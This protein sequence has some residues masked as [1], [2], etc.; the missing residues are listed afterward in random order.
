MRVF[1]TGATGFIGSH[2]ARLLV[3]DGCEVYALI[4][5]GSASL[6]RVSD[7]GSRLHVVRGDLGEPGGVGAQLE[8]IKP[9][10][11]IH[12]A[13]YT[14]PNEYLAAHQNVDLLATSIYLASWL[15]KA[16]T[17]R[18]VV[19]G[20][21][22]EYDT[23]LGYLSEDSSTR[24]MSLYAAC[25][26]AL[27]H[28]LQELS[29]QLAFKLAWLRL[30]YQYGPGEDPRRLT[31]SVI[32]SLLRGQEARVTSGDQ[33]RDYLYVEDVAAAVWAVAQSELEGVVNVGS[34]VPISVRDMVTAIADVC[35]RRDLISL[36]AVPYRASDP[37]FVCAVN[38]RLREGTGWTPR[39]EL[40][41]G[42]ER[43]VAWWRA[44]GTGAW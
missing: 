25:K 23:S 5:E 4:R 29:R 11:C 32:L 13:W 18:L 26:L 8:R 34:G 1:L 12:L 7:I 40:R 38:K 24:P 42:I 43:T 20:T 39:F 16:G 15:A 33:V 21:C 17:R 19:A 31:S 35:G 14:R 9:E 44:N 36:G 41:D 3:H 37:T 30:F 27:F 6:W 2:V 22:L 10:T 28:V